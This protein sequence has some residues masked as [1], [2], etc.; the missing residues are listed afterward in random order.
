MASCCDSVRSTAPAPGSHAKGASAKT[1]VPGDWQPRRLS[2][3]S[4]TS[5]TPLARCSSR[6]GGQRGFG[7]S[8]MTSRPRGRNGF[9]SSPPPSMRRIQ[10]S[11]TPATSVGPGAIPRWNLAAR[12]HHLRGGPAPQLVPQLRLQPRHW[13]LAQAPACGIQS[14]RP[15]RSPELGAF[16]DASLGDSWM[17]RSGAPSRRDAGQPYASPSR[18]HR[19]ERSPMNAATRPPTVWFGRPHPTLHGSRSPR[20]LAIQYQ[21]R[22]VR[23]QPAHAVGDVCPQ[24]GRGSPVREDASG[25]GVGAIRRADSVSLAGKRRHPRRIPEAPTQ[26]LDCGDVNL[27]AF[28]SARAFSFR[29]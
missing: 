23:F 3:R 21:P 22:P 18:H 13:P 11:L 20:T 6:W 8:S 26:R 28:E 5:Q 25:H 24:I 7:T 16:T 12:D 17:G 10:L 1:R 15:R 19:R 14:R 4:S 27:R 29:S 9:L 2:R